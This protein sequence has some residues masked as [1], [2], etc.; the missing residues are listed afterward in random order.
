MLK[1][2]RALVTAIEN[3]DGK[4]NLWR[5]EH[6]DAGMTPRQLLRRVQRLDVDAPVAELL[7]RQL[8]KRGERFQ[9]GYDS[10]KDHWLGWLREYDGP[11][12]YGR[13]T[14]AR[15]AA[16]VYQH[17]QC[18]PMLLWLAEAAGIA[19]P[20]LQAARDA[21]LSAAPRNAA[22]CRALREII[23]WVEVETALRGKR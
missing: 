10:Q 12:Y 19:R 9:A 22:R 16:F 5:W 11:G 2:P 14:W 23:P 13:E 8:A 4:L 3:V 15:N 20:L 18:A 7:D 21:V 17:I 6:R 1:N